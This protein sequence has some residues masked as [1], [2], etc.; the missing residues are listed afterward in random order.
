MITANVI[1][2]T[3]HLRYGETSGTMFA[4]DRSDKQYLVT[5]RHVVHGIASEDT[6]D[7]YWDKRWVDLSVRRVGVGSG[8][9]DVVVMAPPQQIAP[10]YALEPTTDGIA[11]GQQVFFLGFPFGWDG[12]GDYINDG[13]PMP[14]VK[15]GIMSA[16]QG[17]ETSVIYVDAHGNPGFS[18]GPL[19]F[20]ETG[21]GKKQF[22]VAGIVA[23]GPTPVRKPV[24]D[25]SGAPLSGQDG[26]GAFVAENQGFVVAIDIKHAVE[27]IDSNPIGFSLP[28]EEAE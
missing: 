1:Q 14:F 25:K 28:R 12:L 16:L 5:A 17:G 9:A 27:M 15:G 20:R 18:G 13:Y 10:S 2:R 4:I 26:M 23:K 19:V 11:Y 21:K 7:I 6:I 22:K 8:E 3:F 24:I